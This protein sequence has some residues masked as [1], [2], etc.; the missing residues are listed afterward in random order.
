M[1]YICATC[2]RSAHPQGLPLW[3]TPRIYA[4][5]RVCHVYGPVHDEAT[6]TPDG[7]RTEALR[8]AGMTFTGAK[9][10]LPR[11]GEA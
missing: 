7:Q 11:E 1:T 9:V 5:C 2:H 6:L 4:E 3:L 8:R 10:H